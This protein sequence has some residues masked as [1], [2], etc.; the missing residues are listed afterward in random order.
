MGIPGGEESEQEIENLLDEML[1]ENFPNP[2]KELAHK[3][4]K[5]KGSQA[6]WTQRGLH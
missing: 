3:S 4:R 6:S 1:T 5:L 2:V